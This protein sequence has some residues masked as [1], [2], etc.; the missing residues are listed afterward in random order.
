METVEKSHNRWNERHDSS[1]QS[2]GIT[3]TIIIIVVLVAIAAILKR[4][5]KMAL[6]L[7]AK[8][9]LSKSIFIILISTLWISTLAGQIVTGKVIDISTE[10]ALMYVNIGVVGHPRG[11]LTDETGAF[12][13][14]ISGLSVN[15]TVRISMI[16]YETQTF[17][18]EQLLNDNGG[19]IKLVNVSVILPEIV[20]KPGKLRKVGAIKT[21]RG[22][23]SQSHG[24]IL[25]FPPNGLE[26]GLK[27]DLGELPALV[28]KLHVRVR[29]NPFDSS[30]FRLHIRNIVNE[31]PDDDLLTENIFVPV[32]KRSGWVVI[33]LSKYN[34]VFQGEIFLSLELLET[35]GI[36]KNRLATLHTSDGKKQAPIFSFNGSTD[37][38][39]TYSKMSSGSQWRIIEYG[40]VNFYLT[41]M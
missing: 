29:H 7:R 4:S 27:L 33:D 22:S 1:N 9:S 20:V 13:L 41:I 32:T 3:S 12:E 21:A 10:E 17:T 8:K 34:L 19:I 39:D 15:T 18:I 28:K 25:N 2:S 6:F 37:Q 40:T 24:W 30:L 38:F 36:N 5:E 14:E 23:Q 11:C 16:G 35:K 26:M 31:L